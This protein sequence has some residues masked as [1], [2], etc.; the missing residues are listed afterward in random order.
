MSC[1]NIQQPKRIIRC[2]VNIPNGLSIS[3]ISPKYKRWALYDDVTYDDRTNYFRIIN[4]YQ[5][6]SNAA[7]DELELVSSVVTEEDLRENWKLGTYLCAKCSNPLYSSDAKWKG[8]CVWPSF[9]REIHAGESLRH[10]PMDSYNNYD[11]FVFELRCKRCDLFLGHAFEDGV[12]KG[13]VHKDARWR[14]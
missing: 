6:L 13:D 8:P 3:Q 2:T 5:D 14:H 10:I 4:P 9:R 1:N 11:C 7:E 12:K